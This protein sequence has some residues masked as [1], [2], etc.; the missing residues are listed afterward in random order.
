[1][2]EALTEEYFEILIN[3]LRESNDIVIGKKPNEEEF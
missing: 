2:I 3:D 1:M